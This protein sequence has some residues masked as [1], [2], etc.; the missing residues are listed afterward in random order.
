VEGIAQRKILSSTVRVDLVTLGNE[1]Q[2]NELYDD[3]WSRP[4]TKIAAD[5]K[6]TSTALKKICKVMR[7]PT[8]PRGHW[9]RI[10][11]GYKP[12]QIRLPRATAKTKTDRFD[13]WLRWVEARADVLD[14]LKQERKPWE[15]ASIDALLE[16]GREA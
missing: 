4:A 10:R 3:I 2:T 12:P 11:H 7:I 9:A 15:R 16:P 6:I 14:P 8:P 13:L 5:L 1:T